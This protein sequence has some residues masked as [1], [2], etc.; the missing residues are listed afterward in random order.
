MLYYNMMETLRK[1]EYLLTRDL[2]AEIRSTPEAAHYHSL[3]DDALYDRIHQ[4]IYHTYKRHSDWL[5]NESSKNT[6]TAHYS[7]LGRQRHEEG[8]PLHEVIVTLFLIKKRVYRCINER[9]DLEATYTQKQVTDLF[10]NVGFFFD[11]MV[12]S[13]VAGYQE[14]AASK[15]KTSIQ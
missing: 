7:E 11:R 4:V 1:N 13:V 9:M 2:V 12:Q 10:L 14:T 8:I 6:V 15:A 3:M 5:D